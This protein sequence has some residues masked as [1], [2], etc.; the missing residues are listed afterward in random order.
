MLSVKAVTF[1]YKPTEEVLSLLE[2]FRNMVNE[3]LRVGFEKKPK[4]R[5]KLIMEVYELFKERYGLHTHYILNACECAFA[6]LR[7]RK[8][9]ING[10]LSS[11]R[12]RFPSKFF[13]TVL[14]C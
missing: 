9:W 12:K 11:K 3:A 10:K 5:F 4:S 2:T 6:M 7:N 14:L 8:L 13:I 1:R